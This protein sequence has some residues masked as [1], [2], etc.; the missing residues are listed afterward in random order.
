VGLIWHLR[1]LTQGGEGNQGGRVAGSPL[2]TTMVHYC[3]FVMF[4]LC[5]VVIGGSLFFIAQ[6][7]C[8]S[9][10]PPFPKHNPYLLLAEETSLCKYCCPHPSSWILHGGGGGGTWWLCT[11]LKA[12]TV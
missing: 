1:D 2:P 4:A 6:F 9:S 10:T 8:P 5:A 3:S 7:V 11:T 12:L